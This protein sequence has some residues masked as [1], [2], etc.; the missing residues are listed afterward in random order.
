MDDKGGDWSVIRNPRAGERAD[1]E[2]L[3]TRLERAARERGLELDEMARARLREAA[4]IAEAELAR[5]NVADGNI[6]FLCT[7]DEGPVHLKFHCE[8]APR[9]FRI[10]VTF[11]GA[12]PQKPPG[13]MSPA[14]LSM[15]DLDSMELKPG[16]RE[17]FERMITQRDDP[18]KPTVPVIVILI[19]AC[20]SIF[21]I[22]LLLLA[23]MSL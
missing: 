13:K 11:D 19:L 4:D 5:H 23:F 21:L 1:G 14:R 8:R 15:E 7:T 10:E 16:E 2:A 18:A 9:S 22:S 20:T 12:V 6:P 3:A 17:A